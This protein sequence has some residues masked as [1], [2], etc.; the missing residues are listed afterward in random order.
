[1]PP[2]EVALFVPEPLTP[3][4]A[5]DPITIAAAV[6][7]PLVRAEKAALPDPQAAPASAMAQVFPVSVG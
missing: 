3:R 4:L 1:M 7:V 5:P 2:M 6:L